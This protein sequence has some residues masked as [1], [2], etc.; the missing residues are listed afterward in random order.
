M[1][2][3]FRVRGGCG[4]SPQGESTGTATDAAMKEVLQRKESDGKTQGPRQPHRLPS[5]WPQLST[6][7]NLRLLCGRGAMAEMKVHKAD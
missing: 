1:A 2:A 6:P 4:K 3:A 7:S 5:E